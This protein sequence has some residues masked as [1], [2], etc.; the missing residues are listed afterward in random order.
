VHQSDFVLATA[1]AHIGLHEQDYQSLE[2][3]EDK[4]ALHITRVLDPEVHRVQDLKQVQRQEQERD[5][6]LLHNLSSRFEF[7][8]IDKHQ[9]VLV[10]VILEEEVEREE[11]ADGR[12]DGRKT[13]TQAENHY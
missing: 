2:R 11:E 9:I 4:A 3:E 6:L 8:V 5:N 7:S 1:I 12:E 13:Q 10:Y